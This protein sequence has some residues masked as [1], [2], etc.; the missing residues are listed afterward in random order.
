MTT[1]LWHEIYRPKTLDDYLAISQYKVPIQQWWDPFA[2]YY[3]AITKKPDTL[4]LTTRPFL[5][6]YGEPGTGKTTLA[7]CLFAKHGLDVIE[8]NSSDA[9]SKKILS[10]LINT[11]KQS[12]SGD[13]QTYKH[14][15]V[16][17]DELDGLA[18]GDVGGVAA[19]L[20]MA[21]LS[22]QDEN[23]VHARYPVICTTN[24]IKEKKLKPILDLAVV[25]HI[26]CPGPAQILKLA[27]RI[28]KAEGLGLS[29][30]QLKMLAGAPLYDYRKCIE[31]L[32]RYFMV[33]DFAAIIRDLY[34]QN[35]LAKYAN[36]PIQD[37]IAGLV[38]EPSIKTGD[39]V[40]ATELEHL[41]ES[42]S[43]MFYYGILANGPELL[44][45][46]PD[47]FEQFAKNYSISLD[48]LNWTNSHQDWT[49]SEYTNYCSGV[50]NIKL[51]AANTKSEMKLPFVY[52]SKYNA[53]R[54]D[55]SYYNTGLVSY[56]PDQQI[57]KDELELYTGDPELFYMANDNQQKLDSASASSLASVSRNKRNLQPNICIGNAKHTA[58]IMKKLKACFA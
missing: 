50:A 18:A 54:S 6:L 17:M 52:H 35:R 23:V 42:D 14:I 34:S 20:E 48:W 53:M 33:P 37:C 24:S 28:N 31:A 2:K 56:E 8:V 12:V 30:P 40:A 32:Y 3:K 43:Q 10:E 51:M 13:G 11:G 38:N 41:I 27:E 9:R 26:G 44:C 7:H 4:L 5:V 21:V 16:I 19:L 46:S 1:D 55:I 22:Q 47:A 15:G 58:N 36:M 29:V 25:I 45:S 57:I 49:L 39:P